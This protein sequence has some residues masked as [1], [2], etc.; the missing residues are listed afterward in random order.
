MGYCK[1]AG[2]RLPHSYEWQYAAQGTDGRT[3]PW[4]WSK[5][6]ANYPRHTTGRYLGPASDVDAHPRGLIVKGSSYYRPSGSRWYFPEAM[7]L[8]KHNKYFVMDDSY[9]R[10]G[11]LGFRCVVDMDNHCYDPICGELDAP[12]ASVDL[13]K[14]GTIDWTHYGRDT[15]LSINRKAN[16]NVI[17]NLSFSTTTR[18]YDNNPVSFRWSDGSPVTTESGTTTGIYV[19]D[20]GSSFTLTVPAG[21]K[22]QILRVYIGV[23]RSNMKI[24][25]T[26]SDGSPVYTNNSLKGSQ[27]AVLEINFQTKT[28]GQ[29]LTVKITGEDDNGNITIQ[30]STLALAPTKK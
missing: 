16:G 24:T 27:N 30:A 3:Y 8:N 14:E 23:Y 25:A 13:T 15:P 28:S 1:A 26:L 21:T 18:Q 2:K 10:A 11:T 19:D 6:Q 4:G 7:E 12:G 20:A 9:D 5:D 22:R 17:G 29:T